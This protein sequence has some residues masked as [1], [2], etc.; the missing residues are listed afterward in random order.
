M[1]WDFFGMFDGKTFAYK[2]H[3]IPML[4]LYKAK[5]KMVK[6]GDKTVPTGVWVPLG[7]WVNTAETEW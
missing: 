3:T 6:M 4:R 1:V 7:D 5:V 2:T